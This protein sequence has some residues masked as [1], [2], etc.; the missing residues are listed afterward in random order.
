MHFLYIIYSKTSDK[1]YVG[2]THNIEERILKHNAHQYK[3]AFSKIAQDWET[4]L[5]KQLKSKEE[6]VFLERFIKR[7]KSR[8]FILKIIDNP[9]I[10]DDI[11]KKR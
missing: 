4:K 8:K 9:D 5:T 6:A 10:L 2:E 7:M 1:Y 11:L 3:N